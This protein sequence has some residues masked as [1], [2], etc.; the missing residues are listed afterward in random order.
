MEVLTARSSAGGETWD[1]TLLLENDHYVVDRR[2]GVLRLLGG[3]FSLGSRNYRV[4]MAAG[5]QYGSAQPYVPP[6]LE[7]LCIEM[8]KGLYRDNRNVSSESIGTWS[9]SYDRTKED[10]VVRATLARYS[11]PHL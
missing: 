9:R 10:P 5:F 3:N 7:S 6:D 4:T 2:N 11:R 1:A 8:A